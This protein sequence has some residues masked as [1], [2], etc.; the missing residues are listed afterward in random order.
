M[1]SLNLLGLA[2]ALA[3]FS[4]VW[5][6]HV[7]V[8]RIEFSARQ[9]HLPMLVFLSIGLA[10]LASSTQVESRLVSAVLGILGSTGL[11]D[12]LEIWRQQKRVMKGHAPANPQNLR[13]VRI[14]AEF[15]AATTA[16]LLKREPQE[17]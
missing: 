9:I 14:L 16:D 6:G 8:R 2:A 12:V 10:L 1:E 17:Y 15:P 3:T 7:A 11:W 13:H 4:G 5:F